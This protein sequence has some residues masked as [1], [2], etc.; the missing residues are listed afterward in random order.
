[1]YLDHYGLDQPPFRITPHTQFFFAGARRGATLDALVYA[2]LHDEG[3]VKVCGEVGSGKT[4]LCR[5]LIERLPDSVD[6]LYLGN[7]TLGPEALLRQIADEL[8]IPVASDHSGALLSAIQ[9]ELISR[10]AA[11]RRI[12][13]LM[14]EAH[15]MPPASLE[16]IRLLSNLETSQQKL[17]QIVLFGQPELNTMLARRD[18]RQLKDRITQNFRLDPLGAGEVS[19]YIDFRLRTAGYRGPSIFSPAAVS[20]ISASSGGLSRRINVLADKAMLAA[21]SQNLHQISPRHV[22]LAIRDAEYPPLRPNISKVASVLALLIA[23]VLAAGWLLRPSAPA[24]ISPQA[25]AP[26]AAEGD[27]P[28]GKA[29]PTETASADVPIAQERPAA[30]AQATEAD[31]PAS[32]S[33]SAETASAQASLVEAKPAAGQRA[34]STSASAAMSADATS[35]PPPAEALGE[36]PAGLDAPASPASEEKPLPPNPAAAGLGPLARDRVEASQAWISGSDDEHWFIQLHT[37][38]NPNAADLDSYIERAETLLDGARLRVYA[39]PYHGLTRVGVIY[40]DYDDRNLAVAALD[41]LP[42]QLRRQGA[43]LRQ[44]RGLR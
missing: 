17:L 8:A 14:D 26:T 29:A 13:A 21:Y 34:A 15:A 16:Q 5:V 19:Q 7:P 39:T 18:M 37:V 44:V 23:V 32:V 22:D 28:A 41:A 25:Q 36:P 2:I 43:Y 9:S 10:F 33:V 35:A 31:K 3:I 20:R 40:G 4:M 30:T 12:V 11:G 27:R 38:N 1:M 42:R 24:T 6:T